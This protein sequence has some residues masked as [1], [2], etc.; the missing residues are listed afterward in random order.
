AGWTRCATSSATELGSRLTL[1]RPLLRRRAGV[2]SLRFRAPFRQRHGAALPCARRQGSSAA[3]GRPARP[4]LQHDTCCAQLR[5]DAV[6]LGEVLRLLGGRTLGDLRLD[7]TGVQTARGV[8]R[9]R[10]QE[11]LRRTL[12][13]TQHTAKR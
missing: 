5:A 9:A 2:F 8:R 10:L 4:V 11:G 1:K 6:S 12:E 3:P 7:R 13:Q